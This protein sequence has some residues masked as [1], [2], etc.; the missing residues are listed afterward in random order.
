MLEAILAGR[1]PREAFPKVK[2]IV[3]MAPGKDS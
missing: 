1:S 2:K 3:L